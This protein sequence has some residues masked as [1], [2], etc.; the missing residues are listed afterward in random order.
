MYNKSTQEINLQ[1]EHAVA[2]S[3]GSTVYPASTVYIG[4]G[5]NITVTTVGGESVQFTNLASGSILPVLVTQVT[6]ASASGLV[7]LN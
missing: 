4:T 1:P 7:L 6:A 2:I 5:G 3:V